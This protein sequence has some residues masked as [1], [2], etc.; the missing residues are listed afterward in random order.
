MSLIF[1]D[2]MGNQG[3]FI[4]LNGKDMKPYFTSYEAMVR[5]TYLKLSIKLFFSYFS[6]IRIIYCICFVTASSECKADGLRQFSTKVHVLV[7]HILD[8]IDK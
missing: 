3:A 1:S 2:T 6:Y 7:E 8:I 4:T 5:N